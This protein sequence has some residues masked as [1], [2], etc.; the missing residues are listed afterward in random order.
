MARSKAQMTHAKRDRERA[1]LEK[2]ARKQAKKDARKHASEPQPSRQVDEARV[3]ALRAIGLKGAMR[4]SLVERG[5]EIAVV[6][7]LLDEGYV[8][9]D[10]ID[11][12][13]SD[14]N[15]EPVVV[16]MLTEAGAD[17][18]GEDPNRIGLA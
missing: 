12:H 14:P 4:A 5:A 16:M 8:T 10:R 3:N 18:I 6:S 9:E 2:R 17:A 15:A 11:H 7:S 13:E 1:Q